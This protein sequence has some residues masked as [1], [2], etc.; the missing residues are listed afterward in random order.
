MRVKAGFHV[1]A[2]GRNDRMETW[3]IILFIVD[4]R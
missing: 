4:D 1:M 3:S 2:N